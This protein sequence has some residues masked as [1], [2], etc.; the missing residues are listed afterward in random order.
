M[1]FSTLPRLHRKFASFAAVL[2]IVPIGVAC[3]SDVPETVAETPAE[4]PTSSEDTA[5]DATSETIVDVAVANGSFD[6]LVTAV[7]AADLVETL[8][9]EGPYT[10]F[11]PTD[12]AFA[13]LPEGVLDQLLLP[14]NKDT[15]TQILTYHVISAEVPSSAVETG[16][17][18]SVAGEELNVVAD[19]SGV[20]VNDA[21]VVAADVMASNGI[22]HVIDAVLLPPSLDLSSL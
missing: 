4:E 12:E 17:V 21:T 10:V 16:A 1:K 2:L 14:E 15:L 5:A 3:G 13:A 9:S 8:S 20:T 22:I 6:T 18:P 11:A 19:E 7:Q